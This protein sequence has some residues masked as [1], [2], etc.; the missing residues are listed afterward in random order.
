MGRR[1][2]PGESDFL[3]SPEASPTPLGGGDLA[4]SVLCGEGNDGN[5]ALVSH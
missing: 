5:V 1:R 4:W 2:I 3:V